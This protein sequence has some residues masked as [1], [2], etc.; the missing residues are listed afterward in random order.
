MF[1]DAL[2]KIWINSEKTEIRR[3]FYLI[4]LGNFRKIVS[5]F[6]LYFKK[7]WLNFEELFKKWERNLKNWLKK[8]Y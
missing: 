1:D 5:K 2:E 7:I 4:F 8:N 3:K 6:W